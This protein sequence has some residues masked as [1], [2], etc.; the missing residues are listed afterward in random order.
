MTDPRWP[1]LF[2][3]GAAKAGTT[4]LYH[5]L[6]WHPEI[7]MSPMKEPHFFSRIEPSPE[8]DAF[9][10][11]VTDEG[12]YLG[13]FAGAHDEK[14]RGEASTSYLSHPWVADEIQER[15]S[16]AK[17]VIMLRDPVDRAYSHYWN[18][19]REGIEKRSFAAAVAEELEGPPAGWGVSSLYV[20]CGFYAAP[21]ER[22]LDRFDGNVLVLFFEE[23]VV[24]VARALEQVF[25]FLEVDPA[26][27]ARVEPEVQNPFALPR[28]AL[29]RRL[30]GSGAARS[31]ARSMLPRSLRA[32][33]RGRLVTRAKKPPIEPDVR[34][35]LLEVFQ[36]DVEQI[37]A[38][39]GR[40]PPWP[41]FARRTALKSSRER[42]SKPG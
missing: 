3:V 32:Y 20:D 37:S 21:F 7:F 31:L 28:N 13:L 40:R 10:P 2:I 39:L 35:R 41:A 4:S 27:A 5:Y 29:S 24:D 19:V 11:R 30:L 42:F 17:I 25:Q 23:F 12:A 36:S 1:N 9:F 14:V 6:A 33:G 26:Y 16:D 22:Y 18:D 38:I 8:L 15:R 34:Q